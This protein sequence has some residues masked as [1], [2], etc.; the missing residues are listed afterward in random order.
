[1]ARTYTQEEVD[2]IR[3]GLK[4]QCQR[5]V[6]A[7]NAWV[8]ADKT[9]LSGLMDKIK[10]TT[11][12]VTSELDQFDLGKKKQVIDGLLDT[13]DRTADRAGR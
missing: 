2:Q 11:H 10:A 12:K 9:K 8:A 5:K 3:D 7:I 4:A 6:D 13:I 1:M